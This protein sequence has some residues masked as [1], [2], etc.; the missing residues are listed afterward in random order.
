MAASA[1][2]QSLEQWVRT[3]SAKFAHLYAR[4]PKETVQKVLVWALVIWLLYGVITLIWSLFS[5]A[6][7]VPPAV[8]EVIGQSS[9]SSG[10]QTSI[11]VSVEAG[12]VKSWKLFG[13]GGAVKVTAPVEPL[14]D[15]S[16][17]ESNAKE[18]RLQLTLNGVI[19]SDTEKN[20]RAVIT[21]QGKQQQYAIGDKL[22]VRGRVVL[23]RLLPDR[24]LIDNAG[25]VESLYLFDKRRATAQSASV[26]SARPSTKPAENRT[27]IG[28]TM[29]QRLLENPMSITDVV[30]IS[31]ARENGQLIGYKV[32]PSKDKKQFEQLGLQTNDVV[33]A[34]NGVALDNVSNAMRVFQTLRS[35]TEAS[36]DI[37]RNGESISLVVSLDDVG[38][39]NE[40]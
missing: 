38:D 35:E 20:S 9:Q 13:K 34:V 40:S 23:R 26:T 1:Q 36:F 33:K 8:A 18:T 19:E 10:Q 31:E 14:A 22:P 39:D 37:T 21:Y 4:V 15:L 2:L 32:R 7:V 27:A 12:A 6:E 16:D 17:A 28:S 29:R 30:R 5:S 24:V 11:G 3:A 25:K